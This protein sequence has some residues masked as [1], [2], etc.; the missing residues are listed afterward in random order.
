MM[1]MK[2]I[3]HSYLQIEQDTG[4]QES[5]QRITLQRGKEKV[6]EKVKEKHLSGFTKY[7][8]AIPMRILY[9]TDFIDDEYLGSIGV[10]KLILL[11]SAIR[12]EKCYTCKEE[13]DRQMMVPPYNLIFC[14]KRKRLRPDG[15][16][17][18]IRAS[19]PSPSFYCTHDMACLEV[20]FPWVK[21]EDIYM[22]NL[23]FNNLTHAYKKL[24]KMKGY[25]DLIVHNRRRKASFQ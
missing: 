1:T 19:V 13:F 16:G 17:G 23:T 24:L 2:R 9:M 8:V 7:T 25:W 3:F 18:Q 14:W 4:H 21:K 11:E 12:V 6:K 5:T 20:E 15:K 22:G 10:T